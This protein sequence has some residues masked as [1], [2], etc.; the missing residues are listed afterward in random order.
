MTG[1]PKGSPW[2]ST[3]RA[4]RHRKGVEIMLSPEARAKLDRLADGGHLSAVVENLILKEPEMV[5]WSEAEYV[6]TSAGKIQV[7]IGLDGERVA[8]VS[9]TA[10]DR[11]P[12][13]AIRRAANEAINRGG[14]AFHPGT[15]MLPDGCWEAGDGEDEQ[16]FL[17]RAVAQDG[18]R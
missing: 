4:K 15:T 17:I 16:V 7:H 3:S 11:T 1:N 14:F 5:N 13:S 12:I 8:R 18:E 10:A 9:V 6:D 2:R